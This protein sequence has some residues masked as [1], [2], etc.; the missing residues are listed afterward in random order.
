MPQ[1]DYGPTNIQKNNSAFF[2]AEFIDSFGNITIPAG[3]ATLTITYTNI[4]NASQ[5]DAFIM[6][7]INSFFTATWSSTSASLGLADWSIVAT[8]FSSLAQIGQ[9]R[10]IDP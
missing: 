4:N 9:I 3:G 6:T 8:G 2:T 1:T 7:S 5:T 10:V